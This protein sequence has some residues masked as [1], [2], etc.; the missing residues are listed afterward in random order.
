[1]LKDEIKKI[2]DDGRLI[3]EC[4]A[5]SYLYNL[6]RPTSDHDVRGIYLPTLEEMIS[7]NGFP[8]EIADEKED[9]KYYSLDKFLRLAL[10]CNPN[11]IELLFVP[12]K[13]L[14]ASSQIYNILFHERHRFI[15]KKAKHTFSGYAY[16]QIKKCKGDGKKANLINRYI[17]ENELAHWRR[18]YAADP[19]FVVHTMGKNFAGFLEKS[20][21]TLKS[22]IDSNE[23]SFDLDCGWLKMLPN[24]I[25]KYIKIYTETKDGLSFR[26]VS[27]DDDTDIYDIS[28]VE[29]QTNMYRLYRNGKGFIR[30]GNII[31]SEISM[32]REREDFA[33]VISIDEANYKKDR[34]EFD[35]FWEWMCNRN[36]ERYATA[37]NSEKTVDCKNLMHCMR[38]L[39]S[40]KNIAKCGEPLIRFDGAYRD[41]LLSIREGKEDVDKVLEKCDKMMAELED[42]FNNSSL[43]YSSD[44]EYIDRL[45]EKIML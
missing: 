30:G 41:Y 36:E 33:G 4:E 18:K 44:K 13:S 20:N 1:M 23:D 11:I 40:G 35:N 7:L 14:F 32:E 26:P 16:A 21:Y 17:N 10:E 25:T 31:C 42:D 5:G 38:L 22:F 43:P 19:E 45:F 8:Q 39:L 9:I 6:N 15:S 27:F 3:M 28:R 29:G 24:T 37:W 34:E 2:K 12:D